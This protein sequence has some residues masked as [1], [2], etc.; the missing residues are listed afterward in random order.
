MALMLWIIAMTYLGR[1]GVQL[2]DLHYCIYFLYALA[3]DVVLLWRM[4]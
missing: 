3:F 1:S 2:S 4:K